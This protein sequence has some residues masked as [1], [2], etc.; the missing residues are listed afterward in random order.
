MPFFTCLL[1]I[2]AF[3]FHSASHNIFC[4]SLSLSPPFL[5]QSLLIC[6]PSIPLFSYHPTL[7]LYSFF[8]PYL[9][10]FIFCKITLSYLILFP[11]SLL[12]FLLYFS[13]T[14]F[15]F[16]FLPSPFSLSHFFSYHPPSLTSYHP[17]SLL[18]FLP[19]LFL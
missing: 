9:S 15:F 8:L 2:F 10:H 11:F 19:Y 12:I 17:P 18:I 7:S 5:T 16:L 4:G 3:P 6:L 14:L 13:L 1:Q